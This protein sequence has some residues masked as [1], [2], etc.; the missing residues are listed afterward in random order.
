MKKLI[1]LTESDLMRIVK[2]VISEQVVVT[3]ND[4]NIS[5]IIKT[6]GKLVFIDFWASYC[7]PCLKL[8]KV[9]DELSQDVLYKDSILIG[10]YELDF[11]LPIAK[12]LNIEKIPFVMVYKNGELVHTYKGNTNPDRYKKYM[13]SIIEKFK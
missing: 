2:R 1:R 5:E 8:G 4:S 7:A 12:K 10:K 11:D 13:I 9:F 3:V 6:P